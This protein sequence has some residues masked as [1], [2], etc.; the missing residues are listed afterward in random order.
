MHPRAFPA[1]CPNYDL[2]FHHFDP[3]DGPA[4]SRTSFSKYSFRARETS[5]LIAQMNERSVSMA[6]RETRGHRTV[7]LFPRYGTDRPYQ[8]RVNGN[9]ILEEKKK[10]DGA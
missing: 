1:P 10:D 6:R 5:L 8:V 4:A 2:Y 3:R 9:N 7:I